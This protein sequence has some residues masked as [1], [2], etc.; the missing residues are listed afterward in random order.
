MSHLKTPNS[1]SIIK[2]PPLKEHLKEHLEIITIFKLSKRFISKRF[3]SYPL[4]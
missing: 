1:M 2:Q 3:T 4:A